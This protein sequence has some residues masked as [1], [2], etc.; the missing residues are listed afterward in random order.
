MLQ[1]SSQRQ[2]LEV[3]Y[4]NTFSAE[5]LQT[6]ASEFLQKDFDKFKVSQ[7][8]EKGEKKESMEQRETNSNA[9]YYNWRP[10]SDWKALRPLAAFAG[11][12]L[13]WC[14]RDS[15]CHSVWEG[16]H[17]WGYTIEWPEI[18]K[19]TM[20]SQFPESMST[21]NFFDVVLFLLSSLV[22]GRSFMSI[23]SLVLELRKFSFIRDWPEIRK[24]EIPPSEFCPISGDWGESRVPN[25]ARISLIEC[26]WMLQ[27]SRVTAFTVLELLKENQL[28]RVI[29][30]PPTTTTTQITVKLGKLN[31]RHPP[32]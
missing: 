6:N 20:T 7:I 26:Y 10:S 1:W 23:S 2:P 15:K 27:N 8:N 24:W 18:R 29:L 3:L 30:P 16:F 31:N 5:Q 19:M 11:E 21:S 32:Y 4:K 12:F 9:S 13:H 14:L 22:T 28:G 25:L 17:H